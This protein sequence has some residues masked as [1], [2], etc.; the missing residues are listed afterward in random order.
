MKKEYR[1]KYKQELAWDE[2]LFYFVLK[3]VSPVALLFTGALSF[4]VYRLLH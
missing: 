1:K 4:D 2:A 3:V